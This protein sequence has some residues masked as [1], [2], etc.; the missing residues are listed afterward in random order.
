MSDPLDTTPCTLPAGQLAGN[1][2]FY[3]NPEPLS[4]EMHGALGVNRTAKPYSFV[5][6][7]HIV[8]LTV[9]EFAPAAPGKSASLR[10]VCPS[11]L[12]SMWP[13]GSEGP[14]NCTAAAA[15]S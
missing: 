13:V 12:A 6:N 5:A 9:T 1:V 8:P 11:S 14:L 15:P 4:A 2:L 7:T 3:S 10:H